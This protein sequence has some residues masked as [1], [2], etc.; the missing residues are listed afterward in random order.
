MLRMRNGILLKVVLVCCIFMQILALLPHHHHGEGGLPCI[1][2][3]HCLT[4]HDL[5]C[6]NVPCSQ[7][8]HAADA[9]GEDCCLSHL[10]IKQ[11]ESDTERG[12]CLCAI[13][14]TSPELFLRLPDE[15][16]GITCCAK[17]RSFLRLYEEHQQRAP[18]YARY[19][20]AAIPPRAPSFMV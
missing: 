11:P 6:D 17:V 12:L 13:D 1:N 19:I 18:L 16:D 5:H 14:L 9:E 8:G 15:C 7:S 3:F 2:S 4:Q 20:V 10:D